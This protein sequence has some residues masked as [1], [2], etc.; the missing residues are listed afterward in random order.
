MGKEGGFLTPKAIGNRIK[1]K[2]LQRLRW[3]CQMCEK[4]CRDENGFRSHMS[5][6]SHLR[7]MRVFADNP[8]RYLN[9]FSRDFERGFLDILSHRHGKYIR[10]RCLDNCGLTLKPLKP[11][12]VGTK[13]V[14]ANQVYQEY[15][16]DKNHVHMNATSWS[17]LSGFVQHLGREGKIVAEDTEKGWYIQFIDRDPKLL[18]K[19]LQSQ[20]REQAELDEEARQKMMIEAQIAAAASASA[21]KLSSIRHLLDC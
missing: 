15:I 7:Q 12:L 11:I 20:E 2:G 21:G 14:K 1:A 9:E 4:Q 3:Y 18:A 10:S 5:S 6:E 17:S 8:G 16:A 19:Q 13:R